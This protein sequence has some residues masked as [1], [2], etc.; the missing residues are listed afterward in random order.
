[1]GINHSIL[2][3]NLSSFKRIR[4]LDRCPVIKHVRSLVA[5]VVSPTNEGRM[6]IKKSNTT[7]SLNISC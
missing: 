5:A 7:G 3:D 6:M 4:K 1:M 2:T